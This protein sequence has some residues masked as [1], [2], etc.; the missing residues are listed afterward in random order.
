MVRG[1]EICKWDF[2]GLGLLETARF[3]SFETEGPKETNNKSFSSKIS[4]VPSIGLQEIVSFQSA[5]FF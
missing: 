4:Q 3:M 1:Q 2:R 5:Y